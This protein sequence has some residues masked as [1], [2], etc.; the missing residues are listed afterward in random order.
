MG[1]SDKG[2]DDNVELFDPTLVGLERAMSGAMMRQQVLA[3]NLANANTPGFKRSDVDFQSALAQAFAAR[4]T[5]ARIAETPFAV[6]T[7]T[8]STV[9]ADGSNVDVDTEMAALSETALTYNALTSIASAR[10][11][12][13]KTAIGGQL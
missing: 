8:T 5:A 4:G 13:L 1:S 11:R 3:N 7:D 6:Q 2:S 10:I 9:R 12:I